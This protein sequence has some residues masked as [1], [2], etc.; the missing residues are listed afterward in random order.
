MNSIKES[1]DGLALQVTKDARQAGLVQEDSDGN[2]TDLSDVVVWSFDGLLLVISKSVSMG[3]RADLVSTAAGDTESVHS[4]YPAK[5]AVAGNGY[6][7]QLPGCEAA[8][9]H[10]GDDA[11]V[12][13]FD[14]VLFIHDGTEG[15]L[16]DDLMA[17]RQEQVA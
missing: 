16:I 11:P 5:V 9:F 8:G 1:A 4:G 7:V 6:Q 2:A 15:R 13:S 14:G 10:V 12:R 3:H 17:I